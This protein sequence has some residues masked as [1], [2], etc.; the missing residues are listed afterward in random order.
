MPQA[1]AVPYDVI[2]SVGQMDW[3]S[4]LDGAADGWEFGKSGGIS[5]TA[6]LTPDGVTPNS[7]AQT[8]SVRASKGQTGNVVLYY[9]LG[10][11]QGKLVKEGDTL[12]ISVYIRA[13]LS[14]GVFVAGVVSQENAQ[15]TG[16]RSDHFLPDITAS[17]YDWIRYEGQFT[18]APG[19]A[20]IF[21]QF[22]L[23]ARTDRSFG[24]LSLDNVQVA[25]EVSEIPS[26]PP[27]AIPMA[28]WG[29]PGPD[30]VYA[31]KRYGVFETS[32]Y[33][34]RYVRVFEAYNPTSV[35]LLYQGATMVSIADYAKDADDP[36]SFNWMQANHPEWLLRDSNG[37]LIQIP[38]SPDWVW[39]DPGNTHYQ[40]AWADGAIRNAR[41][42]GAEG[43]KIDG[44]GTGLFP[45]KPTKYA[46]NAEYLAAADSF[47]RYVTTRLRRAGLLVVVNASIATW[48]SGPWNEWVQLA[49]GLEYE[50]PIARPEYE[51]E[52]QWRALLA[53]YT[54]YPDKLYL[55]DTPSPTNNRTIFKFSVANYLLWARD[56][57]Y[58]S[59]HYSTTGPPYD[60]LLD[61]QM[62]RALSESSEIVA[63]VFARQYQSGRVYLNISRTA[64]AWVDIPPGLIDADTRL[65][66]AE[67]PKL[68]GPHEPLI[69]LQA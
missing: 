11:G 20:H 24:K 13:N 27:G 58:L 8:L 15:W 60:P 3:D 39:V 42:M 2:G 7:Y 34:P 46:T 41:L 21:I 57:S 52:D 51:S 25:K 62:G 14:P 22:N 16:I 53:S 1:S 65:P 66:V 43:I 31:A 38:D 40:Q 5:G 56:N 37:D 47:M 9:S 50:P 17:V 26:P 10:A 69:L 33:D 61:I 28:V 48:T 35:V 59:L 68:L 29:S 19:A 49:D 45:T 32:I 6:A 4:N 30:P 18:V 23:I 64:S 12:T 63:G 44:M 67:G 36:V 54:K 55:N